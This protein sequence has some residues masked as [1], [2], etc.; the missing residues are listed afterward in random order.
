MLNISPSGMKKEVARLCNLLVFSVAEERHETLDFMTRTA[1]DKESY[2]RVI[3]RIR[4]DKTLF[5]DEEPTKGEQVSR[6]G[7]ALLAE[8]KK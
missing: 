5:P 6:N 1:M 3:P 7:A 4:E 2:H 8:L